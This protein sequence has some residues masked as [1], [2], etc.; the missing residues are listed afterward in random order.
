MFESGLNRYVDKT[1]TIT[2]TPAQQLQRANRLGISVEQ[3]KK[4][5][6]AQMPISRKKRLSDYVINNNQ[7]LNKT[8]K[9]VRKIWQELIQNLKKI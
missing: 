8:K 2:A 5:I 4:R 6:Q 7:N 9:Q 1:I 3:A